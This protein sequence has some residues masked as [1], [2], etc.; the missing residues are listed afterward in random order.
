ME[1]SR[2]FRTKTALGVALS[3][4]ALCATSA[5]SQ[6]NGF[7]VFRPPP[8]VD[9][10]TAKYLHAEPDGG[11]CFLAGGPCETA[12]DCCKSLTCVSGACTA[13]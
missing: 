5:C 6:G 12:S 8:Q 3:L 4:A 9:A 7:A 2:M 10:G 13:P 1:L 11:T